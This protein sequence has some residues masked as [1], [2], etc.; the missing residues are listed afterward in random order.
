MPGFFGIAI[1]RTRDI[2][3]ITGIRLW[4]GSTLTWIQPM[5]Q[6]MIQLVIPLKI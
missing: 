1:R 2:R 4:I 6:L 3:I 5:I